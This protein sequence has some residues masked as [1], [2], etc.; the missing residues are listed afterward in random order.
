MA[1]T[2]EQAQMMT[3]AMRVGK[4]TLTLRNDID[5]THVATHGAQSNNLI[6]VDNKEIRVEEIIAVAA[7]L[8]NRAPVAEPE[9]EP[10]PEPV[11]APPK[12]TK[13]NIIR[14]NNSEV[15]SVNSKGRVRNGK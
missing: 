1:R 14:G 7:P 15:K 10:E 5:V 6:G 8:D 11:A 9:P 13:L 12:N 3:H 4:V 2:S